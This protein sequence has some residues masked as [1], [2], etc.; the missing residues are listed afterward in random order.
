IG[1]TSALLLRECRVRGSPRE[2]ASNA[3]ADF[4]MMMCVTNGV[5]LSARIGARGTNAAAKSFPET[6]RRGSGRIPPDTV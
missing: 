5:I 3:T 2:Q 6:V 4:A 1:P